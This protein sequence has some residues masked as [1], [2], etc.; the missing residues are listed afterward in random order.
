M[1]AVGVV[2]FR[3]NDNEGQLHLY[4]YWQVVSANRLGLETL[5]LTVL[6]TCVTTSTYI[7]GLKLS[8]CVRTVLLQVHTASLA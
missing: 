2:R 4:T 8:M 1:Y 6:R 3:D 7:H 5:D